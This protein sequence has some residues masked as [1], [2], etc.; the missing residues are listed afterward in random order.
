M[1]A[2]F[3]HIVFVN[4]FHDLIRQ[5]ATVAQTVYAIDSLLNHIN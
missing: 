3:M 1:N 5:Y 2:A 4:K